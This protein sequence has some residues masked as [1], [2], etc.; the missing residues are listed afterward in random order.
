MHLRG[1]VLAASAV[2]ALRP[3][4]RL[5]RAVAGL[6]RVKMSTTTPEERAEA[7]AMREKAGDPASAPASAL[8]GVPRC[9]LEVGTQKYVLVRADAELFVSGRCSAEYHKDAARP[10]LSRLDDAG[11]SY[12]VLGGGRISLDPD[13]KR[14]KIY[15]FSYGFPWEGGTPRHDLAA[16]VCRAEYPDFAVETSD[17]GY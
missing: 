7:A 1:V 3:T 16:E 6:D 13:A 4:P 11:A 5:T 17:E 15:G 9:S 14:I 2:A 8:A 12:R 10:L